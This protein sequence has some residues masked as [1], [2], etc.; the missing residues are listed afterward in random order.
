MLPICIHSK[1]FLDFYSLVVPPE[2]GKVLLDLQL[3]RNRTVLDTA[4]FYRK[5]ENTPLLLDRTVKL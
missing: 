5:T 2:R 1:P 3:H 4:A